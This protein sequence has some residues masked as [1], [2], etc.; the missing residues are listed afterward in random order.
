[1]SAS[2]AASAA[3]AGAGMLFGLVAAVA[4]RGG[5]VWFVWHVPAGETAL[6]RNADGIVVLTGGASRISDAIELLAAGHGKRLLI[7]GVHRTTIDGRDRAHQSALRGPGVVLRRPRP[8]G[9]STPSA[10]RS[11]RGAG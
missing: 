10:T 4:I 7:S 5:F 1:M 2:R 11:R 6:N 9:R 3:L 8:F